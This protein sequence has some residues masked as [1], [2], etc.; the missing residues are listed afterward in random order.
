MRGRIMKQIEIS[1][2]TLKMKTILAAILAGTLLVLTVG[3]LLTKDKSAQRNKTLGVT[4]AVTGEN[5]EEE[6]TEIPEIIPGTGN[7]DE[8]STSE[9]T[10]SEATTARA[11]AKIIP[12]TSEKEW[13]LAI[14]SEQYPLPDKYTP[15]LAKPVSSNQ[16]ELDA[17]IVNDYKNMYEA[18]KAADCILTPYSGYHSTSF[19]ETSYT[20]KVNS[21]VSQGFSEEE[22]KSKASHKVQPAGCSEH[23]AGIA[24]DIVSASTDFENTKEFQWLNENAYKFGFVLRYPKDKEAITGIDYQPWHWRYVGAY[25]AKE[26]YENNLCLEEYLGIV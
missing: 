20:R 9:T 26:M 3:Y 17:R 24:V 11:R 19:Q 8:E 21:F 6:S 25:A 7:G 15:T 4:E 14:I 10:S 22:A 5:S 2:K 1:R 23:N 12:I 18:A 13:F 16:T